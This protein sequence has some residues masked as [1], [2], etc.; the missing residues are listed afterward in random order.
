[1]GPIG[2]VPTAGRA[3][4]AGAVPV[5]DEVAGRFGLLRRRL[6]R[7]RDSVE[8]R[9]GS[10]EREVRIG[11]QHHDIAIAVPDGG[12]DD[13]EH[14]CH[15]ALA[16]IGVGFGGRAGGEAAGQRD[17]EGR[18]IDGGSSE[19]IG[20]PDGLVPAA[21]V[22]QRE[23]QFRPPGQVAGLESYQLRPNFEGRLEKS[24]RLDRLVGLEGDGGECVVRRGDQG[25]DPQLLR[26]L[27]EGRFSILE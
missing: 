10:E 15:I 18:A 21:A 9:R 5:G 24:P 2:R 6:E 25:R 16:A 7:L 13:V 17:Q 12:P 14:P 4:G 20:L 26:I 23:R 8:G 27:G 11:L 19:L 22:S 3:S 1:M